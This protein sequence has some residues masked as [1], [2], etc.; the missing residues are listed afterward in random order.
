MENWSKTLIL[1]IRG[2]RKG[3]KEGGNEKL[4]KGVGRQGGKEEGREHKGRRLEGKGGR[5]GVKGKEG[6]KRVGKLPSWD[7]VAEQIRGRETCT[8]QTGAVVS[9]GGVLHVGFND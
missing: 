8:P 6:G 2:E 3:G 7:S 9:E 4:I 5:R 1:T